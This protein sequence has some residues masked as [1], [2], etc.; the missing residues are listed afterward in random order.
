M[1]PFLKR[2]K[3]LARFSKILAPNGYLQD[4]SLRP[5]KQGIPCGTK[6]SDSGSSLKIKTNSKILLYDKHKLSI[7]DPP[8]AQPT[9]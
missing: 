9:T 2:K 5:G 4:I 3:I 8:D 1:P 6:K 7:S